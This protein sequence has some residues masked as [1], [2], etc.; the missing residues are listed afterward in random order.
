[1][2][3][4]DRLRADREQCDRRDSRVDDHGGL[5]V[6]RQLEASKGQ[7]VRARPYH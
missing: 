3:T 7:D 2:L 1:M 6:P 5:E 4:A